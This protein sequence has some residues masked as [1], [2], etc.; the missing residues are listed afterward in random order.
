MTKLGRQTKAIAIKYQHL[1]AVATEEKKREN[2]EFLVVGWDPDAAVVRGSSGDRQSAVGIVDGGSED[3]VSLQVDSDLGRPER[4]AT[5]TLASDGREKSDSA[6]TEK[7]T[8]QRRRAIAEP[9]I[10]LD[11]PDTVLSE[12]GLYRDSEGIALSLEGHRS[13][14][15]LDAYEVKNEQVKPQ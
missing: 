15:P 8:S 3:V 14:L 11:Q 2:R 7:F 4:A 5:H 1:P 9:Q 6:G 10:S 13:T 12:R